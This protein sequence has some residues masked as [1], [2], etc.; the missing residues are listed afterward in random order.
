[1]KKKSLICSAILTAAVAVSLTSCHDD[2]ADSEK[3]AASS[4]DAP[5][6]PEQPTPP[7]LTEDIIAAPITAK[8]A[9]FAFARPG[10]VNFTATPEEDGSQ[11]IEATVNVEIVENL[12]T[13]QNAPASF[14]EE[15]KALNDSANRAMQP[16]AAY[17]MQVGAST[18]MI[19]EQDRAARPLPDHLQQMLNELRE[20]SESAVYQ[21]STPAGTT[22]EVKATLR[23]KPAGDSW[24]MDEVVVDDTP[25]QEI[26]A[27][28]PESA[29]P[30]GAPVMTADFEETRK[31]QLKE[32]IAAFNQAAEPY[33]KGREEAARATLTEQQTRLQ[34][35]AR[36][37]VEQA[38]AEA[39]ARQEWENI[40]MQAIAEGKIFSGEWVRDN[41]FGEISL[42]IDRAEKFDKAIQFIGALYDTKLPMAS[43]DISGRCDLTKGE[44]G[45][46]RVDVTIYDGQYDPDQ[47]TAEVYDARDGMLLLTLSKDGKLTGTMSCAAW[48]DKPEKAFR[49][50]L[51]VKKEEKKGERK[52]SRR[53]R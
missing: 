46:A 25:L 24:E 32:K 41:R 12:F 10:Q 30:E 31:A 26:D 19:S 38:E 39:A 40:C 21:V 37:A 6:Q 22:V 8:L 53:R 17:L 15:R 11:K 28:N 16:E 29:L 36:K 9:S 4:Q 43:L 20:L 52:P 7:Q 3:N 18:D 2:A 42:R 47:P 1:M 45:G 34:E 23:A 13:R 44:D 33:I 14:S 35:E 48:N 27:S 50:D 49:I 5:A 51:K